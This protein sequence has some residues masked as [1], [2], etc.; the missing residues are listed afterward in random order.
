M[1][2]NEGEG[3]SP[4]AVL[5]Y[6]NALAS[7]VPT[8]VGNCHVSPNTSEEKDVPRCCQ[9][10]CG[11]IYNLSE[12]GT[13]STWAFSVLLYMI[14]TQ[15]LASVALH[16]PIIY[17]VSGFT[18]GI[19]GRARTSR[20]QEEILPEKKNNNTTYSSKGPHLQ[21]MRKHFRL[22]EL[23]HQLVN[24]AKVSPSMNQGAP[25]V[26]VA[27][28]CLALT[29][30]SCMQLVVGGMCEKIWMDHYFHHWKNT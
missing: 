24:G 5:K 8:S 2:M 17:F 4:V 27:S 25:W 26:P 3:E 11:A 16:L 20:T 7:R 10:V 28:G 9:Q 14:L 6:D 22:W 21:S 12:S 29:Q 13:L 23:D 30:A 18:W 19:E 1:H 15:P